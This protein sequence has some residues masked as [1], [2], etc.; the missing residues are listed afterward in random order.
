MFTDLRVYVIVGM[1][2]VAGIALMFF[3]L[4]IIKHSKG[5]KASSAD[6]VSAWAK[7]LH[8]QTGLQPGKKQSDSYH[9]KF[10]LR[11]L[12]NAEELVFFSKALLYIKSEFPTE[13]SDYIGSYKEVF[14]QLA[15]SY[16]SKPGIE[17][18]C[19][20]DFICEFA[21]VQGTTYSPLIDSLISFIDDPN[22][23]CRIN[24]LRALCIIGNVQAV[25][26]AVQIIN[27][28]QLYIH[29]QTLTSELCNFRGDKEILGDNLW[30]R[31]HL[32]DDNTTVAVIQ[33]ITTFS[34]YYR[35]AFMPLLCNASASADM[36]IAVIRYYGKYMYK[37]AQPILSSF[38]AK[39][40]DIALAIVAATALELYPESNT[41]DI[42]KGALVSQNWY[43]RYNASSSLVKL[44]TNSD[45]IDIVRFG[46]SHEK[47]IVIYMLEQRF[48][49]NE[50]MDMGR[51]SA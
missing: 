31:C 15:V 3:N 12:R 18:A 1:F 25:V 36:R 11:R 29:R 8:T 41:I 43:V 4:I 19:F 23:Y 22:I 49:R 21:G 34:K 10:L 37:L 44:G 17:R 16:K 42:L 30:G 2:M 48:H 45:L 32:W 26:N 28:K 20:A 14:Q 47:E 40:A 50:E 39:P 46:D 6:M 5:K 7:L 24:V 35:G 13:Y 38:V 27:D 51:I 9:K 33:F